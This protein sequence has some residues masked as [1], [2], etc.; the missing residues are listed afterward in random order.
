MD[1]ILV[2]NIRGLNRKIKQIEVSKFINSHNM[3]L[4]SLLET[5]VKLPNLGQVYLNLCPWWCFSHNFGCRKN[6]RIILGWCPISFNVDICMV[7]SQYMCWRMLGGN[8]EGLCKGV[9]HLKS[10]KN[11]KW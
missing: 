10:A 3:K 6:G 1:N 11:S 8:E 9:L 2:W 4:F 7:T 5:R